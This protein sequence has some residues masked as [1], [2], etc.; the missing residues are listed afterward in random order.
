MTP[1]VDLSTRAFARESDRIHGWKEI[2]S[3][4]GRGVRTAQRWERDL[5]LPV[6]RLDTKGAEVVYAIRDE[7]DEW[8]R[9]TDQARSAPRIHGPVVTPP[10]GG[11]S[12]GVTRRD[13]GVA[14]TAIAVLVVLLMGLANGWLRRVW[15][16]GTSTASLSQ[17]VSWR[18]DQQQLRVFD[19][20]GN[21]LWD[22][23]FEFPIDEGVY[24]T[25]FLVDG[26]APSAVIDDIDT[27]G[28]A[29]V[30][31]VPWALAP[32][33]R[34]LWC[35]RSTGSVAFTAPVAAG[36]VGRTGGSEPAYGGGRFILTSNRAGG[37]S[38]WLTAPHYYR[39]ETVLQRLD[40]SGRLIGEYWS[41]GT[42]T[43][44]KDVIL[45]NGRRVLLVG[46]TN[47]EL[48][49][50]TL[51]LLD[52]DHPDGSD[53]VVARAGRCEGCSATQPIAYLVFPRLDVATAVSRQPLVDLVQLRG[54]GGF[55][56]SVLQARI[57]LTS[58]RPFIHA[59]VVYRFTPDLRLQSTLA[60]DAYRLAHS[61]LELG[62]RLSTPFGIDDVRQILQVQAW[63]R[64]R[65]TPVG[66]GD[67]LPLVR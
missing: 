43:M 60:T 59:A 24:R 50:A 51:A 15:P 57:G 56:V 19:A 62:G 67:A 20:Q 61:E 33:N 45:S 64:G 44:L 46:G 63:Q 48:Q 55:E 9:R 47:A 3:Y 14:V 38:I 16:L 10:P 30:L 54:D 26:H 42:I 66:I 34:R 36:I 37:K 6:H 17:P 11:R 12:R 18:F 28:R 25:G 7:I 1:L 35:F 5:G 31:L 53:P 39:S 58:D 22:H 8:W 29:E 32:G 27:D 49:T 40:G 4:L 13:L 65:L 23:A 41:N 52:Y 2:A 21:P